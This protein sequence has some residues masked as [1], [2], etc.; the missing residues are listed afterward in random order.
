MVTV[1]KHALR[2][3]LVISVIGSALSATLAFAQGSFEGHTPPHI[4]QEPRIFHVPLDT[5][6][7][8]LLTIGR[9]REPLEA[10]ANRVLSPNKAYWFVWSRQGSDTVVI[11]VFNERDYVLQLRW[12]KADPRYGPRLSW[13]NEKLLY[14]ELWR[15]R[16]YGEYFVLDVENEKFLIRQKAIYGQIHFQQWKQ[17]CR[18]FPNSPACTPKPQGEPGKGQYN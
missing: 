11:E 16:L 9:V 4:W 2:L 3:S 15:G 18:Q 17:G 14:G 12:Q 8:G 7:L 6:D 13:I 5:E 10:G 1:V